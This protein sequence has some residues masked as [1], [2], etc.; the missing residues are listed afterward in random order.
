[1]LAPWR[2]GARSASGALLVFL[3]SGAESLGHILGER[4]RNERTN[5][6]TSCTV[7]Q[8]GWAVAC[9]WGE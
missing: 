9:G 1:M 3:S 2:A 7:P 4:N 6:A 8:T 5:A